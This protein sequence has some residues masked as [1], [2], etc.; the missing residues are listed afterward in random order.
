MN[1]INPDDNISLEIENLRSVGLE[2][3]KNRC[4]SMK[5]KLTYSN[6]DIIKK[7]VIYL[8]KNKFLF[9]F[10]LLWL[11]FQSEM[12]GQL[13][14]SLVYAFN[15]MGMNVLYLSRCFIYVFCLYAEMTSISSANLKNTFYIFINVIKKY[16]KHYDIRMWKNW[17][18]SK[19][20]LGFCA[21]LKCIYIYK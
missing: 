18:V 16:L 5:K 19:E 13:I 4:R 14:L 8:T 11:T 2:I 20:F 7:L 6:F 12:I 21:V 10:H 17:F 15:N 1:I 3:G 9:K